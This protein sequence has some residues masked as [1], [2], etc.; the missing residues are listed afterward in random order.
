MIERTTFGDVQRLRM[1]SWQ[2]RLFGYDVST[3][4]VRGVLVD[5]GPWHLRHDLLNAL[6]ES[7]VRGCVVTHWHEDHAGN[8]PALAAEAVPMWMAP[9]T[10]Q[11]LRAPFSPKLYRRFTW[12]EPPR[13]SGSVKAFDPAPLEVIHAPGHSTDHHV[14]WDSETRTLFSADLWLGVRVRAVSETE[15]PYAHIQSL[16][17]AIALKPERMFDAHRG[18]VENPV[19]ALSAKL[20]WLRGIVRQV[21]ESLDRGDSDQNILREILGGEESLGWLSRGEYARRNFARAVRQSRP[22]R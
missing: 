19:A 8:V 7:P 21:E 1:V 12:G 10:E 4:L 16:E 18:F 13:L 22:P 9:Y 15:N 5:A 14:V 20:V 3:Y 11:T 2:S 6:Q 17:R